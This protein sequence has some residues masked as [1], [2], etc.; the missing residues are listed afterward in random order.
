MASVLEFEG[1]NVD[2]AVKAACEAL[3]LPKDKLHYT[4]VSQGST[5]IF[6]IV[7]VKK[8]KISVTAP[9]SDPREAADHNPVEENR[10][11]IFV[12]KQGYTGENMG[13]QVAT[14]LNDFDPDALE[15][16]AQ[17]GRMALRNII[18]TITSGAS[19]SVKENNGRIQ[20]QVEGGNAA[21]LI[22]KRGQTLEAIQYL[23]E[24]IVN[25]RNQKRVRI[26]VD[27]EG[28]L[29]NRKANLQELALRM[30]EKTK[31][32]G[33]PCTIGQMNAH[34]R[35]I[36]HLALKDDKKV[37]TQSVGDGFLR[38]LVIFPRKNAYRKK[39]GY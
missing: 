12:P 25:K 27:V 5:G 29:Q 3:N 17:I 31:K 8:A 22:G 37:R 16:S 10:E 1:K 36:V 24:K 9:E 7:G 15:N 28:Y 6:G 30:A 13:S 38:K 39:R 18:D 2:M 14:D 21:L 26:Q 34:D 33:K 4:V 23:V 35:R 19:I 20:F 11:Q 32:T